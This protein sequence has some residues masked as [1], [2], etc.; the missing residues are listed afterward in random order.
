MTCPDDVEL[1]ILATHSCL[2]LRVPENRTRPTG[3]TVDLLVIRVVPPGRTSP[4]PMLNL[5]GDVGDVFG[6]AGFTAL[7]ERVHRVAY[8]LEPRGSGHSTP[9]MAC[10]EA[11]Q[12]RATMVDES[13]ALAIAAQRCLIR[14]RA[15]GDDPGW[16]GPKDVAADADAVRRAL[17]VSRWNVITY[18][19]ASMYAAELART[20]PTT[21]RSL[22]VDSPAPLASQYAGANATWVAWTNVAKACLSTSACAQA[23]PDVQDLWRRAAVRVALHA[24]T[25][26][27]APAGSGLL[28]AEVLAR[29]VRAMLAGDGPQA[30]AEVPAMLSGLGSGRLPGQAS[31][32]LAA[33]RGACLGYR[34]ECTHPSNLAAYLTALCPLLTTASGAEGPDLPGVEALDPARMFA[35]ACT[36]WPA[37][38]TPGSGLPTALPTLVLYGD[39]DP[40]VDTTGLGGW[41]HR[42]YAYL[43][44]VPGQTH[45][46]MGFND[47]PI[48][49][50]NA[51][52][53]EPTNPPPTDCLASVP[54][55]PFSTP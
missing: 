55:I 21:I 43:V 26:P 14:L 46:A 52:V 29:L 42:P 5:G 41:A 16:F 9:S 8:L 40:F 38:P 1:F 18:G 30:A 11:D 28:D 23:F 13:A 7:A 44:D 53:D 32:R 2:R 3:R 22:V 12:V 33:D 20:Y 47:C 25:L 36:G 49:L 39:A 35:G 37:G 45:N 10:P 27:G 31:A 48:A 34:P 19:S 6:V 15:A 4:D 51:W 17:G 50:R 54:A 24:V